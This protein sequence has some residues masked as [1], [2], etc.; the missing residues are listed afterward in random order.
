MSNV[1]NLT[2]SRIKVGDEYINKVYHG[3]SLVYNYEYKKLQVGADVV[4]QPGTTTRNNNQLNEWESMDEYNGRTGI[5]RVFE[6]FHTIN[7]QSIGSG[8]NRRTEVITSAVNNTYWKGTKSASTHLR[9]P[10]PT[11]TSYSAT[12]EYPS[13]RR[14]TL[15]RSFPDLTEVIVTFRITNNS[16]GN[17]PLSGRAQY[18]E[19]GTVYVTGEDFTTTII[20]G[21]LD[22]NGRALHMIKQIPTNGGKTGFHEYMNLYFNKDILGIYGVKIFIGPKYYE[23]QP[24]DGWWRIADIHGLDRNVLHAMN[25]TNDSSH[26]NVGQLIIIGYSWK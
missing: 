1:L 22:S 7:N 6:D 25:G 3:G 10:N 14:F 2:D 4:T 5:S 18:R 19:M 11:I 15:S 20:D 21:N 16:I 12:D 26:I 9:L 8:Y 13:R 23:A 24:G 17:S